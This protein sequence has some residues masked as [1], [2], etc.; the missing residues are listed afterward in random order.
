MILKVDNLAI[1]KTKVITNK[2]LKN[3]KK[4]SLL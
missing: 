2:I 4:R 1:K 3:A